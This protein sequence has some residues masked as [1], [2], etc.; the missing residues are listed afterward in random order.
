MIRLRLTDVAPSKLSTAYA[1]AK[2]NPFG[3]HF[4]EV[5]K[6]RRSEADEFY[7]SITPPSMR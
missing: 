4:D 2:G 5:L 6:T 1:L 7:A 3:S